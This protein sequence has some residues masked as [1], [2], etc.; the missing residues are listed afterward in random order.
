ML[1]AVPNSV[2]SSLGRRTSQVVKGNVNRL[3]LTVEQANWR[4]SRASCPRPGPRGD[5]PGGAAGGKNYAI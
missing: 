4:R 2:L 1:R 3:K 5:L